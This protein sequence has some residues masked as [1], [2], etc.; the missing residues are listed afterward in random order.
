M[1]VLEWTKRPEIFRPVVAIAC[2]VALLGSYF[3]VTWY[4]DHTPPPS[5]DAATK[6]VGQTPLPTETPS[7]GDIVIHAGGDVLLDAAAIS[8][9][10]D[11]PWTGVRDIFTSDDLTIV[12]LECAASRLGEAQDKQFT[13]RCPDGLSAMK[14]N[15]VDVAN[16]GNNHSG[17]YGKAAQMDGRANITKA[18]LASV[19]TGHNIAEANT[20]ATFERR[21]KTIA[22]L[23][24]GGVIPSGSW[25]ATAN[26]PGEANGYDI[27]SMTRAVLAAK[28][29]ADLVFV[30]IHWGEELDTQPRADDVSRAHAMIDAGADGIFGSH[31]HRMQPLAFYK[32]KP[33]FFG[34]GNFV[35][36]KPGPTG[37]AEVVVPSEGAI[38]ACLLPGRTTNGRPVLDRQHC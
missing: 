33:I 15:G 12:S 9:G 17:D 16:Q 27:T 4:L 36:P 3:A 2:L 34:L 23:G 28:A 6:R 25:L 38:R 18:G 8:R 31:A 19:G 10:A 32:G 5:V 7:G 24:F 37:V 21:G 1:T 14:S 22:V 11:R 26:S 35:W 20:P 13:F 30:I 29:M